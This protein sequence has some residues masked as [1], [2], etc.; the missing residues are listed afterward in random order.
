[1]VGGVYGCVDIW[2]VDEVVFC[3]GLDEEIFLEV[4]FY[5][6][7]DVQFEIGQVE[8]IVLWI[9]EQGSIGMWYQGFGIFFVIY[10]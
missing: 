4:Y 10:I 9:V 1:M 8:F 6:F 2:Y 7:Y 3:F 5:R